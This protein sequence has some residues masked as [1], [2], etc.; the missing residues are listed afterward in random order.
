MNSKMTNSLIAIA[1]TLLP[2]LSQA[3]KSADLWL[4]NPDKS[5]L[6]QPQKPALRFSK[7]SG[8]DPIIEV[9][10]KQTFQPIDGFGFA[11]TGGSAQLLMRMDPAKRTA[12]LHE[13]FTDD[14]SNIGTSYIR[15]SVGASD[16]NDHVFSYDNLPE[17]QTHPTMAKFSL[18]PDRA[19]VIPVLKLFFKDAPTIEIYTLPLHDALPISTSSA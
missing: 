4:T 14:G 3:Q 10:D 12:I 18:D 11:L 16:M 13:L 5:V 2:L 1:L 8:K 17:G 19:D 7:A 6:F 9:D 15:V